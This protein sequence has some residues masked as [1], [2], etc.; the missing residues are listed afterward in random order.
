MAKIVHDNVLD[1]ALD[2]IK[3]NA[4]LMILCSQQPTTRTEAVTTYALADVAMSSTDF[5]HA[6]G[7]TSGRKT[8]VGAKNSVTVDASGT[9]T[10]VALVDGTRLLYVTTCTSQAVTSGNTVNFPAWDIELADPT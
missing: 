1:G 4:N 2:I 7:D 6:N 8:T 3:N 5:T 10:H 9:G